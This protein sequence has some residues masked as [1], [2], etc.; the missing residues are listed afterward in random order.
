TLLNS[1]CLVSTELD[2]PANCTAPIAGLAATDPAAYSFRY[3]F[4][5]DGGH[6]Y[7]LLN[8]TD[9]F[10]F[11][12][13]E[14][15]GGEYWGLFPSPSPGPDP[16]PL[17][18][19]VTQPDGCGSIAVGGSLHSLV[20]T[21][22][23]PRGA[24]SVAFDPCAGTTLQSVETL[25]AVFY[26]ALNATMTVR[27]NGVLL[28]NFSSTVVLPRYGVLFGSS[29]ACSG[30]VFNGSSESAGVTSMVFAGAYLLLVQGCDNVRFV[31]WAVAGG[32]SVANSTGSPTELLVQY[33][34]TVTAEYVP[35]TPPPAIVAV[36][37]GISPSTCGPL[38][39]GAMSVTNGEQTDLAVGRYNVSAPDCAGRSFSGWSASSGISL[40][41]I[42]V[43]ATTASLSSAASLTATYSTPVAGAE[44]VAVGV[45]PASC[46]GVVGIDGIFYSNSTVADLAPGSHQ[47][48]ALPC[49][50]ES[51][52]SWD[53]SGS[54]Q[55]TGSTL[56]IT[57]IGSLTAAY[58]PNTNTSGGGPGNSSSGTT[59]LEAEL[60]WA[61]V[62]AVV[63]AVVALAV[64]IVYYRRT[65]PPA[66]E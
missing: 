18:T 28:A 35:L 66:A 19:L 42:L 6:S 4:E 11:F 8:A 51:F 25:G 29:I 53:P 61:A 16:V 22:P 40:G 36:A 32:V 50:G 24:Y 12:A 13:G 39:F 34:G 47:L 7:F 15:S 41:S 1:T 45:D 33:N 31:G 55:V 65:P 59:P 48:S 54:V 44:V 38:M 62:G 5:P 17:L 37:F 57:G 14:V 9:M 30:I 23:L 43:A 3:L 27:G 64:A 2:E 56:T 20:D 58:T 46:G 21:V 10:S 49:S 26:D 52:Q 60:S 63:G